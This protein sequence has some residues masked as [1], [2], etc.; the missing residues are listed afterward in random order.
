MTAAEAYENTK[1]GLRNLYARGNVGGQ[2]WKQPFEE[3]RREIIPEFDPK[4]VAP[5]TRPGGEEPASPEPVP[6]DGARPSPK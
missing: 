6:A 5:Q 4:S 1:A 3:L 2:K